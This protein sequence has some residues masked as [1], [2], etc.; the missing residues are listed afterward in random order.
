MC[1]RISGHVH[2][3][4]NCVVEYDY[5]DMTEIYSIAPGITRLTYTIP[6]GVHS[7]EI[8]ETVCR[9]CPLR[10]VRPTPAC[11]GLNRGPDSIPYM[12]ATRQELRIPEDLKQSGE[13]FPCERKGK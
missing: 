2:G 11:T 3:R 1:Q 7:D 10:T 9:K 12:Y 4:L 8:R 13:I 6:K 5:S